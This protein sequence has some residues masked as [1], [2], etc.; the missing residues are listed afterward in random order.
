[1]FI[2]VSGQRLHKG[3]PLTS[4]LQHQGP[5]LRSMVDLHPFAQKRVE[6]HRQA[7][8]GRN[9]VRQS[10]LWGDLPHAGSHASRW[11]DTVGAHR[12]GTVVD[13]PCCS[14]LGIQSLSHSAR[15][16]QCESVDHNVR[17]HS[18]QLQTRDV[19]QPACIINT[20]YEK[21][22]SE[23]VLLQTRAYVTVAVRRIGRV[24]S[25]EG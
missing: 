14:R 19:K 18:P 4:G 22:C 5:E 24:L 21:L 8:G 1:V 11:S 3:I 9:H 20:N 2:S 10:W 15:T 6:S 7:E 23:Y 17:V 12:M 16:D 25:V 13:Q